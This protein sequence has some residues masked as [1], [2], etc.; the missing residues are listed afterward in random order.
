ML[1]LIEFNKESIS[2]ITRKE[3]IGWSKDNLKFKQHSQTWK[4][5]SRQK[6]TTW[7]KES[8]Q[9]NNNKEKTGIWKSLESFKNMTT[10][11]NNWKLNNRDKFYPWREN[12]R[13]RVGHLL[14]QQKQKLAWV[15][16]ALQSE[17]LW[18][19]PIYKLSKHDLIIIDWFIKLAKYSIWFM[20]SIIFLIF[21]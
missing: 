10:W 9:D 3:L 16:R 1:R 4:T 6:W 18:V 11:Q 13:V 20:I 17:S 15:Q 7:S 2:F 14:H 8:K 19:C 12:S 5:N 21:Y